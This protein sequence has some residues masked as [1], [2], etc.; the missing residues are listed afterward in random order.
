MSLVLNSLFPL[1]HVDEHKEES[2]LSN[3]KLEHLKFHCKDS[4]QFPN[5]V[6]SVEIYKWVERERERETVIKN[7]V[8]RTF[9]VVQWLRGCTFNAS[10]AAGTGSIPGW[11][12]K[13]LTCML[14]WQKTTTK[15]HKVLSKLY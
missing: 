12:T 6:V 7:K 4:P 14:A 10:N 11:G 13:I 8:L 9:L 1:P 15:T 2:N 3:L 5:F